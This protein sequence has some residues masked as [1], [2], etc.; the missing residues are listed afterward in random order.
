MSPYHTAGADGG[1]EASALGSSGWCSAASRV[2]GS[3]DIRATALRRLRRLT[4][5]CLSPAYA[6]CTGCGGLD[7]EALQGRRPSSSAGEG[8]SRSGGPKE[9][10]GR[11]RVKVVW[12]RRPGVDKGAPPATFGG[13]DADWEG[14]EVPAFDQD[15]IFNDVVLQDSGLEIAWVSSCEE[16][17]D[18]TEVIVTTLA[19]IT[20]ETLEQ[21]PL[22]RLVAVALTGYDHID[23]GA[24][25]ARGI[26]VVNVPGYST[27]ATAELAIGLILSHLRRLEGCDEAIRSG[28]WRPP[29]QEDLR[30]KTVGIVGTGQIGCRLAELFKAF[31]VQRILGYSREP[32]A[33]F[34]AADGRYVRSLAGLFIDADIVCLC[35]PLTRATR[36]LVTQQLMELLRPDSLLVN[37]GRGGVVDEA[38]LA[39]LLGERR[40]RAALD[41]FSYEPIPLSSPLRD[42]PADTLLLTPHVGY[43][44]INSLAKRFDATVNN[45]RAFLAGHPMHVVSE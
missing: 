26:T 11:R 15:D 24:C 36:G 39:A 12:L 6:T 38:A 16:I 32:A 4:G 2:P 45:I 8:K 40:F 27:N 9:S 5:S 3:R 1:V 43:Q 28:K 17:P 42:V 31:K 34:L 13:R 21:T 23:I 41:V 14:L 20:A 18:D 35:L 7:L 25:R 37:V 29:P 10:S 30:F 44:S 22:V 33:D 19:P